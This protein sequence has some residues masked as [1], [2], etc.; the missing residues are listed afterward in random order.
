[1]RSGCPLGSCSKGLSPTASARGHGSALL[2]RFLPL[3]GRPRAFVQLDRRHPVKRH[4][5]LGW[6]GTASP[7]P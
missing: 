7:A 4:G 6:G 2:R 3:H 1:M 5:R